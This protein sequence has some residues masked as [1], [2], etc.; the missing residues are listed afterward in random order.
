MIKIIFPYLIKSGSLSYSLKVGTTKI[1]TKKAISPSK[2]PK[3]Y[4]LLKL[5]LE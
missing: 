1:P 2:I 5:I 4:H 3:I